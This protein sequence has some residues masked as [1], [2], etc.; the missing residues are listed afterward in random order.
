MCGGITNKTTRGKLLPRQ[1][2][3]EAIVEL[4]RETVSRPNR[5]APQLTTPQEPE[6]ANNG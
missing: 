5:P 6:S 3:W 4:W 2:L 1:T